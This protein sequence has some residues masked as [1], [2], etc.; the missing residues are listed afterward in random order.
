LVKHKERTE[1]TRRALLDA[2]RSLFAQRGYAN[3]SV[4]DLAAA[5]GVT[6]G[7][8]YHQFG[9]KEGVFRVV[10]D[11]LVRGTWE[12]VLAGRAAAP[13]AGLLGDCQIYLDACADPAFFR[14]TAD[15]PSVIGWDQLVDGTRPLVEASLRAARERDEL[16]DCPVGPL[17]RL[18]AAALKE[19][20]IMIATAADPVAARVQAT[21]AVRSLLGGVLERR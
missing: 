21:E 19:A 3:V 6:T 1:A 5:A 9:S 17:A 7:A 12:R 13:C 14:I 16:I 10:Y 15:G 2:G 4:A 8:I 20:G 11:E 18:M